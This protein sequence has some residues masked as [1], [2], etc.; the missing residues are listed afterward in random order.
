MAPPS[1]DSDDSFATGPPAHDA[2]F[3]PDEIV[4]YTRS[5][6]DVLRLV[7]Y[8]AL[9][10]AMLALT[11]WG[12]HAVLGFETDVLALLNFLDAPSER[13]LAGAAQ[14]L[15]VV[16]GIGVLIV[17][18]VLKR[19]RLLGYLVV[20]NVASAALVSVALSWLDDAKPQQVSNHLAAGAGLELGGTVTPAGLATFAASFVILAPFVGQRWRRA[21]AVMITAFAFLRIVLSVQL[22]AEVFFALALG[23]AVGAAVLLAFGRPDQ[24]ATLSAIRASLV[25]AALPVMRLESVP[26]S[27]LGS[28]AYVATRADATELYCKVA[29]PE[30]RS[31]DVL[32]RVYRSLRLKNVGDER[33][34]WSLRRNVE[35]EALASLQARDVGVRTPRMRTIS[36]VGTDSMLIAYDRLEGAPLETVD[37][38]TID[39]A[40]LHAIWEQ[41]AILRSHRI[42][43]RDLRRANLMIDPGGTPWLVGFAFSDVAVDDSLIDADVAQLMA[44]LALS[45]GAARA[46]DSAIAVLGTDAVRTSLRLLQVNAL[47]GATRASLRDQKGLLK[48]LQTTVA[49]RCGVDEPEFVPLARVTRRTI[50]TVVML[51]AVTYFLLPQLSDLPGIAS[52]VEAADWVWFIPVVFAS[53]F[54]YLGAATGMIGSVPNRLR[55]MPTFVAQVASSF[56]GTL[57]PASVGSMAL[58]VRYL[59]KSGV[60]PAVAVPAVGLDMVAGL[61][62]HVVMLVVFL[63]WAG[64]SALGSIHLPDP[65][66]FFYGVAVVLGLAVVAF[67]IPWIRHQVLQRALP[68]VR[69]SLSGLVAV[70][71]SPANVAMLVGGSVIVTTGY[72]AAMYLST[73]AFGGELTFAQVGAV[74]LAG[75]TIASVAPTPGGLGALE[76][77][78]IAGLVAAGMPNDVAVPSVFLFRI[79]TFWLPILPGW[80]AFTYLQRE[81]YL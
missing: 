3:E 48:E 15:A 52:Q 76:A 7:A 27:S 31:A 63:V 16:V 47:S 44:A 81:D 75:A 71:R 36:E 70:V 9:T 1:L 60:D 8:G 58:N 80:G 45:V 12:E 23:G 18:I 46:V 59:Q 50:L 24:H 62:V 4:G 33:P 57:A 29:S 64:R 6:S 17:P 56:A 55:F 2:R 73:R 43:H 25:A 28:R 21:G 20:A 22:P 41:V 26:S 37:A 68:V 35:H 66:V 65:E 61:A 67:A 30:E 13:V 39:D 5:A 79:A 54:T 14:L 77:A 11:R 72:L 74:Y 34:F 40:L 51:V 78:V 49:Q 10:L 53:A 38:S 69:R 19:Y 32:S 42:A